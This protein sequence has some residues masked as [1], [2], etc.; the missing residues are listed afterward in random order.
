[1]D[2]CLG[3]LDL[4][5]TGVKDTFP[6]PVPQKPKVILPLDVATLIGFHLLDKKSPGMNIRLILDKYSKYLSG[7][8]SIRL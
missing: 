7:L 4:G 6:K 5:I 3:L 1:M 8:V 2:T